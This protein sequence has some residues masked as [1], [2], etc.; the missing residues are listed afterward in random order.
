MD[1]HRG[2]KILNV[3][4]TT[5]NHPPYSINVAKEGY[6]V[7]KVKGHLPDSIEENDKQLNEM[8]HIWYADHVMGDLSL[9]KKQ[10]IRLHCSSLQVT[11]ANALT[12]LVK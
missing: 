4:M 5:S 1:Q 9:A 8:G 2:E 6:D 7:N 11:I 12:L 3:I 10:Q